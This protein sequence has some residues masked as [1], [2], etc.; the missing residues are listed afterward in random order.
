[1]WIADVNQGVQA[2]NAI[3]DANGILQSYTLAQT[4]RL[5]KFHRPQFGNGTI[6]TAQLNKI[7]ALGP[8]VSSTS[9]SATSTGKTTTTTSSPG[10]AAHT[11]PFAYIGCYQDTST[12]HALPLL[13]ANVSVTPELCEAYVLSLANK[14]TPAVYNYFY[15]EYHQ[16]CYGGNTFSFQGSATSSLTGANACTDVRSGSIGAAV[17]GTAK[18]GGPNQFNL[19]ASGGTSNLPPGWPGVTITSTSISQQSSSVVSSTSSSAT[20][21]ATSSP[22]SSVPTSSTSA[23]FPPSTSGALA[24]ST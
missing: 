23:S 10:S 24:S 6:Y 9:S 12:G 15:V 3:P 7:Y 18:C 13:F 21:A 4:G 20:Q 16:E 2:F 17:T 19:Y 5:N 14:P 11:G 22:S 8:P 1:V